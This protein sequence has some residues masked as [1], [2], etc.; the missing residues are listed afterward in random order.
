[1][2]GGGAISYILQHYQSSECQLR[3]LTRNASSPAAIKLAEKGVHVIQ[4]DSSQRE[5]LNKLLNGA[6]HVFA[7]T[8]SD[9]EKNRELDN[10]RLLAQTIAQ[11]Q[12]ITH[13]VFSGGQRTGID[14]LD[15]K[16]KIESEMREIWSQSQ[17]AK[18][19]LQWVLFLHSSFFYENLLTKSGTKRVHRSETDANSILFKAPLPSN[20]AVPMVSA[21]DIG[22]AAGYAL[23]NSDKFSDLASL[24]NKPQSRIEELKSIQLI[25]QIADG[26]TFAE[27]FNAASREIG[28]GMTATYQASGANRATL[29]KDLPPKEA[30]AIE[31][32]YKWYE[33]MADNA[34]RSADD[35]HNCSSRFPG[36]VRNIHEWMKQEG[37]AAIIRVL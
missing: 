2:Q 3:T 16:A 22:R 34:K 23:L 8:F 19:H 25:G 21:T 11:T 1:M 17:E 7:L 32:M 9:F 15:V 14:V 27:R 37:L 30:A 20:L 4:G 10:G 6:T 26:E 31:I 5:D 13:V 18:R 36:V 28:Q 33:S 35:V 24:L 29:A 12:S